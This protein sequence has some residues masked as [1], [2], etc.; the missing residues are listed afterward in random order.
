MAR[1]ADVLGLVLTAALVFS[2]AAAEKVAPS[3]LVAPASPP[4]SVTA[5]FHELPVVDEDARIIHLSD[6]VESWAARWQLV[7]D[8]KQSVEADYFI[9]AGDTFG[10]SSLGLLLDRARAGVTVRLIVD[11]R[12]SL[13]LSSPGLG[14]DYLQ[15]LAAEPTAT[16]G[17]Y[18]PVP[19]RRVR[20]AFGPE[21]HTPAAT[22][23]TRLEGRPTGREEARAAGYS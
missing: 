7:H 22:K 14:R 10:L 23:R 12:G 13:A 20:V 18:S 16:V 6:N 3:A 21:H 11:G 15:E 5:A 2:C 9:V 17:V 8:A 4:S 19:A 1:V